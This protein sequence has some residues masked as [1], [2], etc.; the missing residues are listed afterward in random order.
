MFQYDLYGVVLLICFIISII[1][2]ILLLKRKFIPD[3]KI[4]SLM[5]FTH[6]IWVLSYSLQIASTELSLKILFNKFEYIGIV[7]LPTMFFFLIL[8]YSGHAA[9]ITKP[10]IF[11]LSIIPFATLVLTAT[12]EFHKLVWTSQELV[13]INSKSFMINTYGTWYWIWIAYVYFLFLISLLILIHQSINKFKVFKWQALIMAVVIF[14]P[15]ITGILFVTKLLNIRH[16][17]FTPLSFLASSAIF[18]YGTRKR[19]L[20]DIIPVYYESIVDNMLDCVIVIDKSGRILFVNKQAEIMFN[21]KENDLIGNNLFLIYPYLKA[22]FKY[23]VFNEYNEINNIKSGQAHIGK[24]E[25]VNFDIIINN[26]MNKRGINIGYIVMLRDISEKIAAENQ[27]KRSEDDINYLSFH[28]KLTGLYNRAYFEEELNR[29]DCERQ[30]PLSFI[31]CDVNGLKI[32]ND[33]FGYQE[34]D[35]LLI[36]V[37]IILKESCRKSDIVARW[38]GDEFAIL[39]LG[40]TEETCLKIINRIFEKCSKYN[41]SK[42]PLS[43]SAGYS[44]KSNKYEDMKKIIIEAEDRMSKRKMLE[45]QSISSSILSSLKST[46]WEKS[47]E[48]EEHA[49]R[50]HDMALELGSALKLP[51]NQLDDLALLSTIHDIGK[52]GIPDKI[53]AKIGKLNDAEWAIMKKHPEIGYRISQSIVQLVSISDYILAHHEAWDGSGYP[54][55]IKGE[56]IPL[57]SR[58]ITLVDAYDVMMHDRPYKKAMTQDEAI[59]E[60]K[61]CSG[62]Q[63]DPKLVKVFLK[64]ITKTKKSFSKK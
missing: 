51:S 3:Y 58:I 14:L 61:K 30:L 37:S 1:L 63:F 47:H 52:I 53:I 10:R 4:G 48:T 50:M 44:T 9:W 57:L 33:S 13:F 6:S 23:N 17:D 55:G 49:L 38:G 41:K 46:L 25:L 45:N 2:G 29:Y 5:F 8:R 39:L 19:K 56:A 35:R 20:G 32:V 28:D 34:G 64:I 31:I 43:L 24:D 15:S 18:V 59:N 21:K 16:Y 7:V 26:Y 36:D 62:S 12:N 27:I 40:T 42:I 54:K 60:I 22:Y 11:F